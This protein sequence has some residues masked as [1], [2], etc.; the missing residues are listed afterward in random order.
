MKLIPKA[1]CL[2]LCCLS[3]SP[4]LLAAEKKS[5][6]QSLNPLSNID[7]PSIWD[8]KPSPKKKKRVRRTKNAQKSP[9]I[10]KIPLPL[11]RPIEGQDMSSNQVLSKPIKSPLMKKK[12][13]KP[14]ETGSLKQTKEANGR[15][16]KTAMP[17]PPP[18]TKWS[19]KDVGLAQKY[20]KTVLA[21]ID[22]SVKPIAPIRYNACGNPAPLKVSAVSETKGKRVAINPPA[23]LN[24]KMTAK[25][26]KWVDKKLQ[27]LA[28]KHFSSRVKMIHNVAS[29]SCRNR[30]NNPFKKSLNTE[31]LSHLILLVIHLKM[32]KAFRC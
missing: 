29:Y 15:V 11:R 31:K 19:Q 18:L 28:L 10:V 30:Y 14:V 23:T 4:P 24:C 32:G 5:T 12:L 17:L 2:V 9:R 8:G 6:F 21:N 25:L 26:A 13:K 16:I 7:L 3:F 27:P 20:C 1:M 22:V